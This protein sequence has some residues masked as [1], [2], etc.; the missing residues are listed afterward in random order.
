[1][2]VCVWCVNFGVLVGEKNRIRRSSA[3][4]VNLKYDFITECGREGEA[5]GKR[6]G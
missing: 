4:E 1:M 5:G 6:R 2:C 3:Y